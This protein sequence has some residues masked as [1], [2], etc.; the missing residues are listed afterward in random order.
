MAYVEVK[1]PQ[2]VGESIIEKFTEAVLREPAITGCFITA[3]K[4]D[5]LLRVVARDMNAYS[6]LAQHV[7]LKLP[8]VQDLQTSFVLES[9]KDTTE[10]PLDQV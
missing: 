5:F 2:I 9:I 1:V 8:G 3:G 7:L 4:C 6:A 10:L